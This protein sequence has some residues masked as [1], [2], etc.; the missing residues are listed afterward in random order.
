MLEQVCIL[1]ITVGLL[2]GLGLKDGL[3]DDFRRCSDFKKTSQQFQSNTTGEKWL[4]HDCSFNPPPT[5]P[6]E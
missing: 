4:Q 3:K 5:C 1:A 6:G 2:L